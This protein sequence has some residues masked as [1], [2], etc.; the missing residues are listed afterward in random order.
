MIKVAPILYTSKTLSNGEHPIMIRLTHKGKRKYIGLGVNCK[1]TLWD[2]INNLPSKK[3]PHQKELVI[4]IKDLVNTIS[5]KIYTAESSNTILTLEELAKS[6]DNSSSPPKQPL[7]IYIDQLCENLK[8]VGKIE[9]SNIYRST[10]NAWSKFFKKEIFHFEE[11]NQKSI[12][13]F[14]QDGERRGNMPNTIYLY[15]RTL[16]TI[17]NIAKREKICGPEYDPFENYSFAKFRRI[18]TR[19]RA[20]S[21]EDFRKIEDLE[22]NEKSRL[23]HS[24]N[25]FIFSFYAGGINFVD[26]AQL[27]WANIENNQLF[28]TRKKTNELINVPL[29][30]K[31]IKI[32]EIY[33]KYSNCKKADFIF[34]ILNATHSTSISLA[35]RLHKVNHQINQDLQQIG[36]TLKLDVKLTTYVARHT[37]ATVLKR[38]GVP[39]SVIG[40]AL[41]HEDEKTTRIYLDS[42][43]SDI[44]QQA[45]E[46]LS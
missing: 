1:A 6:I 43:G 25:Y 32:M 3:H 9:S 15:L 12:N 39:V 26:L 13:D 14:E 21:R 23:F 4:L 27:K 34:P 24:R 11:I 17:I 33:K 41:G 30:G 22:L 8:A 28:Y 37:F 44:M 45:F 46:K 42:F 7:S 16:K 29:M 35:N 40:Q 31:A 19:K 20:I 10:K 38:E 36:E 2:E 18:K 5:K